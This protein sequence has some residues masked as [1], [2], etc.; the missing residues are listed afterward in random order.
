MIMIQLYNYTTYML[1]KGVLCLMQ[2]ERAH[3]SSLTLV[4]GGVEDNGMKMKVMQ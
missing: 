3:P 4:R 1:N 2:L